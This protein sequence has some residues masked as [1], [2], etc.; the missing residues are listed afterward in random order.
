M[1]H[2][3][4]HR[5]PLSQIRQWLYERFLEL[6]IYPSIW[7]AAA[8]A[9]LAFFAQEM[10]GLATDW[11]P[12]ALIFATALIPYNLD[13]IFDTYVQK[14]PEERTQSY[15]RNNFGIIA[16]LLAATIA[17]AVLLYFAP[18]G[19]RY[20]SC[21]IVIPLIYGAPL[22]PLPQAK[23]MRWYRLKDIP[24]S[25]AWIVCSTLTYAVIAL[26]L[27]YAG[28]EFDSTA[29][30]TTLFMFVFIG[31]NSHTF[32]I[33]DVESDREKGVLTLPLMVGVRGAKI[34]LTL[35]NGVMLLAMVWGWTTGVIAFHPE[36]LLATSITLLYIWSLDRNTPRKTYDIAIDGILFVPALSHGVIEAI[37]NLI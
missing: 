19:V 21:A 29:A 5:P 36:V 13:R 11:K 2:E 32:D 37:T 17:T 12:A 34:I 22:F 35:L 20:V 14:K 9:S 25:K 16:L 30:L 3:L 6:I 10:M 24:G 18:S 8:I 7:V 23:G 15:F 28:A 33:P 1:A 27:A 31:S 4:Q 26:T